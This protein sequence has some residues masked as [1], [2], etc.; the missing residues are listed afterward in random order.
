M[1]FIIITLKKYDPKLLFTDTDSLVYEIETDGVHED[2]YEDKYLFDLNSYPEDSKFFDAINKKVIGRMK[3][4]FKG[5]IIS[6]RVGVNS[7]L[8][9]LVS[10]NNEENKKANGVNK[11]VVK[12]IIHKEFSD[13]LFNRRVVRHKLKRIQSKLH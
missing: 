6:E 3:D 8:Y 11:N 10:V 5:K 1:N 13:V 7:N 2:F 9:S 4:E 12:N